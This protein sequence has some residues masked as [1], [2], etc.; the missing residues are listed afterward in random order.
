MIEQ[1]TEVYDVS[2]EASIRSMRSSIEDHAERGWFVKCMTNISN[3]TSSYYEKILVV[4]TREIAERNK[5][6]TIS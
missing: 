6:I 2:G 4:Y 1:H 5:E 3:F